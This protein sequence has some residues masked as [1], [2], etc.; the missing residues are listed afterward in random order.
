MSDL[1]FRVS[2]LERRLAGLMRH[3]T[4]VEADYAAARVRVADGDFQ[5][6]WLPWSAARSVGGESDWDAPE[7]GER[8]L[9]VFPSGEPALGLVLPAAFCADH[10]AGETDPDVIART[11]SDGGR[12][13]Y[14]RS[15]STYTVEP[16]ERGEII[17]K[18]ADTVI[19]AT[20]SKIVVLSDDVEVVA[21]RVD[22]TATTVEV[23]SSDIRLGGSGGE[24]VARVGDK[25]D[26]NTHIILEG[27]NVTTS[28]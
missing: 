28:T 10:P 8:V 23:A 22:V 16:P 20:S 11:H 9:A 7:I 21:D 6:G 17:L 15:T 27:S 14:D 4:V 24:P 3:A 19:S 5:S 12:I 18:V 25:V 1:A 2:E 26:P 13:A